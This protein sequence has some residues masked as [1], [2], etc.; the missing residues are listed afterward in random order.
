MGVKGSPF[1]A[2]CDLFCL[3]GR[4]HSKPAPGINFPV[5]SMRLSDCRILMWTKWYWQDVPG[6]RLLANFRSYLCNAVVSSRAVGR[7]GSFFDPFKQKSRGVAGTEAKTVKN[8]FTNWDMNINYNKSIMIIILMMMRTEAGPPTCEGR[9]R[10][11]GRSLVSN[12]H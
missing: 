4:P 6:G 3:L 8:S 11:W 12:M 1:L 7:V 5:E 10:L 9:E 2:F